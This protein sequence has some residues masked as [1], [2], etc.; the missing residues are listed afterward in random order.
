MSPLGTPGCGPGPQTPAIDTDIA[1]LVVLLNRAGIRTSRSCHYIRQYAELGPMEAIKDD[2]ENVCLGKPPGDGMRYGCIVVEW[3]EFP[4][5]GPV[6][7]N[8]DR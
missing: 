3:S 8:A 2:Q 1:E 4:K 7:P 5:I 6:L